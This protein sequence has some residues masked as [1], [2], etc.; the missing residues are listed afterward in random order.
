MT[1]DSQKRVL[2]I[3]CGNI[4]SRFDLERSIEELP[5]SHAG[6]YVKHGGYK[7]TACL[8]PDEKRR[9]EFMNAWKVMLG[10]T[11]AEELL[12]SAETFDVISIC[13]PTKYHSEHLRMAFLLNP[14]LIFCEKPITDSISESEDIISECQKKNILLAV[15]YSRRFDPDVVKLKVQLEQGA[16][17]ALRS[18][19]GVYNKGI[20][21]NGSHMLDMLNFMFGE[22]YVKSVG[23]AV[24]DY[25]D[26][27][28]T[29]P[30]SLEDSNGLPIQLICGNAKDYAVFE[31]SFIFSSGVVTMEDGGMFWRLRTVVDSPIFNGYKILNEGNYR[32]GRYPEAM[33]SA[34]HNI[35]DVINAKSTTLLSSG[36]SALVTQRLCQSIKEIVCE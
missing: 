29:V 17:G 21:N 20:L 24:Y 23:K 34:V 22:L 6:A 33:L 18:V 4:A 36:H 7:I 28:P 26:D 27:D 19:V 2:V 16:L 12:A 14:Q 30:V 10:F 35:Y 11:S 13:S 8:D 32:N 5:Y 1:I 15:N 9:A 3:G 31:L 25:F